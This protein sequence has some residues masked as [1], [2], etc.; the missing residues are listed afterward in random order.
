VEE[1]ANVSV[2]TTQTTVSP[3]LEYTHV[4]K[5]YNADSTA[6]QIASATAG[7][8]AETC[9]ISG[10]FAYCSLTQSEDTGS[11]ATVYA[12]AYA[13][14]TLTL[15]NRST[16]SEAQAVDSFTM[17]YAYEATITETDGTVITNATVKAGD[18]LDITC[19]NLGSGEYGCAVPVSETSGNVQISATGYET[20]TDTFDTTR[21]DNTDAQVTDTFRL[22]TNANADDD[23]DDDTDDDVELVQVHASRLLALGEGASNLCREGPGIKD[24]K[25]PSPPVNH[26]GPSG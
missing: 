13:P 4:L 7:T 16:D 17:S 24:R 14:T 10:T 26:D 15:I 12:D 21:N 1:S 9:T 2:S 22:D 3:S 19:D 5:A 23:D 18:D 6:V 11:T 20:R 8:S 25:P